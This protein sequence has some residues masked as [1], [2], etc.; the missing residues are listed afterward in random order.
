[1][2]WRKTRV[3]RV[4]ATQAPDSDYVA[5]LAYKVEARTTLTRG[6]RGSVGVAPLH[7]TSC[8]L[9]VSLNAPLPHTGKGK[10]SGFIGC[11]SYWGNC[12]AGSFEKALWAHI[13]QRNS[14]AL[15]HSGKL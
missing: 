15:R 7:L 1:M 9:I 13:L 3:S 2:T 12:E 11:I 4:Q 6:Y 14:V 5:S 10:C 8:G